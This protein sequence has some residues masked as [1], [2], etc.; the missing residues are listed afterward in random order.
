MAASIRDWEK[1]SRSMSSSKPL[2]RARL[3][4]PRR[5]TR[6]SA[7]SRRSPTA[8]RNRHLEESHHFLNIRPNQALVARIAE[9]I[10][11]MKSRH[12]PDSAEVL[13]I[14]AHLADRG[15]Y[16]QHRLNGKGAET[17]NRARAHGFNL[18]KKKRLARSDFVGF[19][20]SIFGRPA[21][22]YVADINV[23]ALEADAALDDIGQQLAGAADERLAT[24]IFVGAG[25]LADE[26]ELCVRIADPEDQV[27][28]KRRELASSAIAD[29]L[30]QIFERR[31][32]F[33]AGIFREQFDRFRRTNG[34]CCSILDGC[35]SGCA[36]LSGLPR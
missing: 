6:A 15:F 20:I 21:F 31:S 26:H 10:C 34:R 8:A 5:R 2:A 33:E 9:Q 35:G 19:G 11:R 12:K 14:A 23:A 22:D 3:R 32:R 16:F 28:A 13:P 27:L 36:G 17:Y 1:D 30:A 18:S 7:H 25:R 4:M 29:E 24:R